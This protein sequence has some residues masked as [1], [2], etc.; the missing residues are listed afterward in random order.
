MNYIY[1]YTNKV[2]QHKYVGQTNNLQ[3]RI[4]EHRSCS[5]N[6]KSCSYNDLIH[7]KIR[8]YG[9]ENFEIT[10]LEKIYS[11]DQKEINDRERYWI[12]KLDTFCG[13]G[14]G[15]NQDL[16][17]SRQY[18]SLV[19]TKE[20]LK[21]VKE[22]IKQG[23]NFFDIQ[24]KYKISPAFISGI[25][26]GIYFFE[27][28]E[29]YPLYKY[30]KEDKDYDELIDLLVNS[31]LT[32]TEIAKQLN[33]GYSTVKKINAGTLRKGLYPTYPIRKISAGQ[34]R[35]NQIINFLLNTNMTYKEIKDATGAS[36]ETIRRINI[37]KSFKKDT[38]SYPLRNL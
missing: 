14:K 29:E 38:L 12:K 3:R 8:Q 33:I 13:T 28:E 15:Y 20:Q 11:G 1:C 31:T 18:E 22:D 37:G 24:Q 19:L 34:Q 32:L 27:E 21:E 30:Y 23:I 2:N 17:G 7:K 26:H 9:E 5:F 36:F 16:G 25:N 6:E 4:R 10:V 35:A